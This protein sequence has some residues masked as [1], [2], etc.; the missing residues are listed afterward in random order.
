MSLTKKGGYVYP[1][2]SKALKIFIICPVRNSSDNTKR[3]LED[4]VT[5]L[6]KDGYIVH[7]P[8][9]DTDQEDTGLDI[10]R[11]NLQAIIEADRIDIFYTGGSMGTHFDMGMAFALGK[12]IRI[13][14]NEKYGAGKS[15]PRMLDEWKFS[16]GE[17]QWQPD[18]HQGEGIPAGEE[19]AP[20]E[21]KEGEMAPVEE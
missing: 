7:L 19:G 20:A 17:D 14:E 5:S 3:K 4:Y 18:M 16:Q 6:E 12:H 13:V 21:D 15:F 10:C 9:R 11:E 1:V 2:S 8:H